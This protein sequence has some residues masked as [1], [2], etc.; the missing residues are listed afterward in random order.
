MRNL[1]NEI[2]AHNVL[3]TVAAFLDR[4]SDIYIKSIEPLLLYGAR[5]TKFTSDLQTL[6]QNFVEIGKSEGVHEVPFPDAGRF[7]RLDKKGMVVGFDGRSMTLGLHAKIP[8]RDKWLLPFPEAYC[9]IVPDRDVRM[10]CISHAKNEMEL[11]TNMLADLDIKADMLPNPSILSYMV[12]GNAKVKE[13]L[14][15]DSF[16]SNLTCILPHSASMPEAWFEP[17]AIFAIGT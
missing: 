2:E 5:L 10:I 14:S 12:N 8:G 13:I 9:D 3:S 17:D 6:C 16:A 4:R 7:H 1:D 11:V 15:N